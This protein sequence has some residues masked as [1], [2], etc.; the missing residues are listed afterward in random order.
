V[1]WPGQRIGRRRRC[2]CPRSACTGGGRTFRPHAKLP[3]VRTVFSLN[4]FHKKANK[5]DKQCGGTGTQ[6][7]RFVIP[8]PSEVEGEES[9]VCRQHIRRNATADSSTASPSPN[10][11]QCGG[12]R[13]TLRDLSYRPNWTVTREPAATCVPATGDC[14]RATPLPTA[15]SSRP[16]S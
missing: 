9:A 16:E 10:D 15:S 7:R 14:W 1:P 3:T 4:Q 5:K 8:T 13:K 12:P 11:K 6:S 2:E